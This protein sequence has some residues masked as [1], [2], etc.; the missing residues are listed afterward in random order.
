MAERSNINQIHSETRS[1]LN[2][3]NQSASAMLPPVDMMNGGQAP[4]RARMDDGGA[5]NDVSLAEIRASALEDAGVGRVGGAT[6]SAVGAMSGSVTQL[7]ELG[8][9]DKGFWFYY[10]DAHEEVSVRNGY[11]RIVMFGKVRDKDGQYCSCSVVVDEVRRN[12]FLL[13]NE[14]DLTAEAKEEDPAGKSELEVKRE[15]A[16]SEA[17]E[18]FKRLGLARAYRNARNSDGLLS[19]KGKFVKRKYVLEKNIA[20]KRHGELAF[21]KVVYDGAIGQNML[22]DAKS[23]QHYSHVFG[24]GTSFLE[25]LVK[26]RNIKGPGWLYIKGCYQGME[27]VTNCAYEAH[28]A[29]HKGIWSREATQK[30]NDAWKE[31]TDVP[32][33]SVAVIQVKT[34]QTKA[35]AEHMPVFLGVSHLPNGFDVNAPGGAELYAPGNT[36]NEVSHYAVVRP[37]EGKAKVDL[38]QTNHA[39]CEVECVES[40]RLML[41]KFISKVGSLDVDFLVGQNIFG[42]GLDVVASRVS[43]LKLPAWDKIGRTRRH[44]DAFS[45]KKGANSMTQVRQMATGRVVCDTL[46]MAKDSMQKMPDYELPTIFEKLFGQAIPNEPAFPEDLDYTQHVCYY[47]DEAVVMLMI[48]VRLEMLS[49]TKQ[50]TCIAGNVWADSLMGKRAERNDLLLIHEFHKNK[51]ICPDKEYASE[52][53]KQLANAMAEAAADDEAGPQAISKKGAQ[54]SGGLV[55]EPKAGL[56]EDFTVML[57]FN[58]LYPSLM[59]EYNICFTNTERPREPKVFMLSEPDLLSQTKLPTSVDKES[60]GILPRVIR[61]L[62]EQRKHVKGQIKKLGI[63]GN[64]IKRAALDVKQKAIKLIANSMYGCLGFSN[65]RFHAKPLAAAITQQGRKALEA[66]K[67]LIENLGYEVIY[68]DTD[69]VFVAART[70]DYGEAEKLALKIKGEVNKKYRKLEID[71]DAVFKRLLLLKKKKYA[72]YKVDDWKSGKFSL[73]IKGLD[74]VRR[75]WCALSSQMCTEILQKLLV[76][77]NGDEDVVAWINDLLKSTRA[78]MDA[79]EIDL[80]LYTITKSISKLPKDY[81]GDAKHLSHVQ[82]AKRMA[83][84]L[85]MPVHAGLEVPYIQCKR[86]EGT[87][88]SI[89]NEENVNQQGLCAFHPVEVDKKENGIAIDVDWYLKNQLHPPLMR[90]LAPIQDTDSTKI[91]EALGMDTSRFQVMDVVG[92]LGAYEAQQASDLVEMCLDPICKYRQKSTIFMLKC[93]YCNQYSSFMRWL[94][95]SE[96]QEVN[97]LDP[98]QILDCPECLR[99]GESF[100]Y[101]GILQELRAMMK[102]FHAGRVRCNECLQTW[103]THSMKSDRKCHF[104]GCKGTLVDYLDDRQ[105]QLEIDHMYVLLVRA[106]R[107]VKEGTRKR[108]CLDSLREL[109]VTLGDQSAYNQVDLRICRDLFKNCSMASN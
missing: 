105:L 5:S 15:H 57:D 17:L 59:Q 49:L 81:P 50:L 69:S 90:L 97:C 101:S 14:Q 92:K 2:A 68:G 91:A 61:M 11:A 58:S 96:G 55:L 99:H 7:P 88:N 89:L 44:S 39:E 51:H 86:A 65:S 20:P 54:Y 1:G 95:L 35:G 45:Y 108:H 13:L 25:L 70:R 83:D 30:R 66:T 84:I 72:A 107:H 76:E 36:A 82:V 102:E 56:Y 93:R 18:E 46:L 40:E 26:K 98:D 32:R 3:L 85:G 37:L 29:N 87:A 41:E 42:Y 100:V 80:K 52:K 22:D 64:D 10:I 28:V 74:L 48:M 75:D 77:E 73:E 34:K 8:D 21:C 24:T 33:M 23:G 16:A 79:G 38:S 71:M 94:A 6:S 60:E 53:K 104:G 31:P 12:A 78:K 106:I 47:F 4:K 9:A 63:E 109:L 43:A 19:V 62:V 67:N 103:D 27:A